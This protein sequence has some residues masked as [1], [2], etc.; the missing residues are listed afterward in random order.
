MTTGLAWVAAQPLYH[1]L[2]G[3]LIRRYGLDPF[4]FLRLVGKETDATFP[5]ER[6]GVGKML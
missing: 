4:R 1:N 6:Y 5:K 2:V 3:S